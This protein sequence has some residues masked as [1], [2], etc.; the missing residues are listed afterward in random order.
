MVE[1]EHCVRSSSLEKN[2]GII[3][4]YLWRTVCFLWGTVNHCEYRDLS[5]LEVNEKGR[6]KL[7]SEANLDEVRFHL[8][9]DTSEEIIIISPTPTTNDLCWK[10]E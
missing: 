10:L 4:V 1:I 7:V 5:F 8:P 2:N 9:S 6:E 3:S